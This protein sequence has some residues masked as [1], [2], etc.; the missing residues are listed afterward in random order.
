MPGLKGGMTASN[1]EYHISYLNEHYQKP[2]RMMHLTVTSLRD[3][4]S[5]YLIKE[6]A[7]NKVIDYVEGDMGSGAVL[8]IADLT[9]MCNKWQESLGHTYHMTRE[10]RYPQNPWYHRCQISTRRWQ[11]IYQKEIKLKISRKRKITEKQMWRSK[12]K[13]LRYC[14]RKLFIRDTC[15]V[16]HLPVIQNQIN[17]VA[18]HHTV[19]SETLPSHMLLDGPGTGPAPS[20][21]IVNNS[22]FFHCSNH[23][24]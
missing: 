7:F 22:F 9:L 16:A 4:P 10:R 24:A 17:T 15:Y 3:M 18:S 23:S 8:N 12:H 21:S 13:L 2:F 5:R 1:A 14:D 19:D 11:Q 6:H 20:E